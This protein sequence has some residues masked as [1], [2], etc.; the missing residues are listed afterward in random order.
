MDKILV[1]A[2]VG[3]TASGKSALAVEIARRYGGTVINADSM[4][5]YSDIEIATAQPTT[6]ERRGVPHKLFGFRSPAE[7][8]SVCEYVE[9]AH[10]AIRAA[11]GQGSLPVVV[12]GSGL[13][14]DSL[15]DGYNFAKSNTDFEER[16]AF[17]AKYTSFAQENGVSALHEILQSVD[18]QSAAVIHENNVKRVIRALE[19]S[20]LD[21]IS[22]NEAKRQSRL[23]DSPYHVLRVSLD[24]PREKLYERI[25]ERTDLMINMGL[26]DEAARFF[27]K[28]GVTSARQKDDTTVT[29]DNFVNVSDRSE[30][31]N[32]HN[33]LSTSVQAIGIKELEKYL[34]G[35]ESL[36]EAV[37]RIKQATRNFAKRQ[38]TWFGKDAR[39]YKFL[40]C[41]FGKNDGLYKELDTLFKNVLK[42]KDKNGILIG[43]GGCL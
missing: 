43:K 10:R 29:F 40:H 39:I 1:A 9:I 37:L 32:F 4:Q 27:A 30:T 28:Y 38:I 12:G 16:A 42:L 31:Q 41:D 20:L 11:A 19:S 6:E 34:S 7:P 14:V 3:A 33:M 5:V 18:S 15:L 22:I 17:R 23:S 8:F 35:K 13:Y 25:N 36:N 2:V 21:G 26:I 24:M